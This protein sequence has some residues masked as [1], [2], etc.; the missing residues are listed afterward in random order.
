MI[1][2]VCGCENNNQYTD[3]KHYDLRN[4]DITNK[5]SYVDDDYIYY[6]GS[7]SISS[8]IEVVKCS[9]NSYKCQ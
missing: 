5:Y 7:T 3:F 1:L 6:N 8:S 4:Y 2:C 9:R